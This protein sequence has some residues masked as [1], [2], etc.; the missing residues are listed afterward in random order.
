MKQIQIRDE[1]I[2]LGQFLK[3]S[4]V[5]SSGIEAKIII[6]DEQVKVNGEIEVRRGKKLRIGDTIEILDQ[7]FEII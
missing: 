6:Q 5:V 2:T 7:Q 1:Y 4:N 3:L